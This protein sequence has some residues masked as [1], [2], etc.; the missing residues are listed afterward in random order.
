MLSRINQTTGHPVDK[1]DE[2]TLAKEVPVSNKGDR[3]SDRDA[4]CGEVCDG[5]SC[6]RE[7][8]Q[9]HLLI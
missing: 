3:R 4:E 2:D 6:P 9:E 5:E 1:N 8:E 7:R